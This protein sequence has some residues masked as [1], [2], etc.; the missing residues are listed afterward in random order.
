MSIQLVSNVTAKF[1]NFLQAVGRVLNMPLPGIGELR[2]E[3][4]EL[5]EY[6]YESPRPEHLRIKMEL[7]GLARLEDFAWELPDGSTVT[8]AQLSITKL[9]VHAEVFPKLDNDVIVFFDLKKP[10]EAAPKPDVIANAH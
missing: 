6:D 1:G 8:F 2:R 7:S 4:T 9:V 3:W 5:V 10:D